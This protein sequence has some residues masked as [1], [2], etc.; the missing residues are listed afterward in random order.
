VLR[1]SCLVTA[2]VL[3]SA[4]AFSQTPSPS[5][6]D[7]LNSHRWQDALDALSQAPQ[8]GA[9]PEGTLYWKAFALAQLG[10]KDEALAALRQ[11]RAANANSGW[12]KE[13]DALETAL[14]G[15]FQPEIEDTQI[16]LEL[17]RAKGEPERV[18]AIARRIW[19]EPHTPRAKFFPLSAVL[20]I[21]SSAGRELLKQ[22]A[23]GSVNPE[24]QRSALSTVGRSDPQFL[25]DLYPNLTSE[26]SKSMAITVLGTQRKPGLILQLVRG[27]KSERLRMV[28]Y[29]ALVMEAG[30][31]VDAQSLLAD[32]PNPQLKKRV[33]AMIESQQGG[34]G[35]ALARLRSP[36]PNVRR[37]AVTS[38]A[39]SSDPLAGP[40]LEAAYTVEKDEQVKSM[41]IFSLMQ[42][43][44]FDRVRALAYAE[45]DT[46]TKRTI[47]LRLIS[48]DE[49]IKT[50]R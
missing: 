31:I 36:D 19:A 16:S 21:D 37:T 15:Q 41:I 39:R 43:R 25:A 28:A 7:L 32:E 40:A 18:I 26:E 42:L 22:V 47:L 1:S 17:S 33:T 49:G 6:Q 29:S 13:A 46:A 38:L 3:L 14:L 35:A 23:L 8:R 5:P 50:I 34:A 30:A 48:D 45:K 20:Q 27:E 9:D 10:R 11:V 44:E 24:M 4:A 2:L 12:H